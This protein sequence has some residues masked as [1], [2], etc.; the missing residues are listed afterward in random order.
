MGEVKAP[1]MRWVILGVLVLA[2]MCA[3]AYAFA[4][5]TPSAVI[6][7][8]VF[9]LTDVEVG[10]LMMALSIAAAIMS[11]PSGIITDKWGVRRAG[12]LAMALLTVGWL[13]SGVAPN[14][15]TLLVGRAIVGLGGVL[16]SIVGPP[17]L[18]GWF[19]PKEIGTAMGIWAVAMPL[20][21]AWEI[22]FA[23]WIMSTYGWQTGYLIGAIFSII[24]LLLYAAIVKPGPLLAPP[25]KAEAGVKPVRMSE[26]FRNA[27]VWKFSLSVFFTIITFQSV[28][29][30]YARWLISAKGVEEGT[31]Y[32]LAGLIGLMGIIAA[33]FSG[34]LSDRLGGRR[35]LVYLLGVILLIIP[36]I[37]LPYAPAELLILVTILLGF[38]TFVI[39][40]HMFSI[41][42]LIVRPELAGLSLGITITFFYIAGIIGV[43]LAGT[44]FESYGFAATTL[45]L[46]VCNLIAAALAVL[47]KAK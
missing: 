22:P 43:P 33:P 23:G 36:L 41:P 19:P 21:L 16:L 40:P 7:G 17:A 5:T 44:I 47:V 4:I 24:L 38:F 34:W 13:V 6:L 32:F 20:G 1:A 39:P 10:Y 30:Y 12:M 15:P 9:N 14:Y 26:V 42:T 11:L 45:F 31:A 29:T 46:V 25:P 28:M 8:K 37:A 18:I 2:F 27:D 3:F 35:K